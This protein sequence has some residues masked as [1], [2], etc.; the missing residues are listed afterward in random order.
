MSPRQDPNGAPA[1]RLTLDSV[2]DA[3][4]QAR[5][6]IAAF[7]ES[8]GF[9]IDTLAT[10]MLLVSELVTNAV[11]HPDVQPPAGI[12]LEAHLAGAMIRVEITDQGSGFA[13]QERDPGQLD[14]GYGL[15][16]LD[17][18]AARWGIEHDGGNTVWFEV[19]A[20]AA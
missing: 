3:P 13:P 2:S 19:P 7:S 10:T 20:Q 12:G 11:R 9:D 4:A 15:Y 6:A 8:H 16:L 18:A 14:G 5:A 1:L 17:K